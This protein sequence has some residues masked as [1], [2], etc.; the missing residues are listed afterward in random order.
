MLWLGMK[1]LKDILVEKLGVDDIITERIRI[2]NV[3]Q[4]R[5]PVDGT[6]KDMVKFL[7]MNGFEEFG[8]ENMS[9]VKQFNKEKIRGFMMNRD[10]DILWFADTTKNKISSMNPVFLYNIEED[11]FKFIFHEYDGSIE[12]Y[13]YE[14]EEELNKRFGF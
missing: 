2:D 13:K 3:K 7:K 4:V 14:F 6:V 9:V 1:N 10:K 11:C 5:F 8:E 12:C